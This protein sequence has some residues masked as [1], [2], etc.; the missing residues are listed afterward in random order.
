MSIMIAAVVRTADSEVVSITKYDTTKG[1]KPPQGFYVLNDPDRLAAVGDTWNGVEY[2]KPVLEPVPAFPTYEDAHQALYLWANSFARSVTGDV[3]IDEKLSWDAKEQAAHALIAETATQAQTDLLMS[4][5]SITGEPVTTLAAVI[6]AKANLY[7]QV[8][9][10]MAGLRRAL[11]ASLK[12]ADVQEDPFA[13]DKILDAGKAQA[14][15][16][17]TALGLGAVP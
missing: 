3:P 6:V 16:M 12:V 8:V 5:A 14:S 7:R 10:R 9:G 1:F 15:A 11:E 13:L 17:A 2:I 4:E